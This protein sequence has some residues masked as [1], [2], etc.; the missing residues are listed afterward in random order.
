MKDSNLSKIL[1]NMLSGG[2]VDIDPLQD[3]IKQ[4]L[5]KLSKKIDNLKL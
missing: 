4:D 5:I 1:D 2:P 3:K